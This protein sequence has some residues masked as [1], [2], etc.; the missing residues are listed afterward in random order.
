M[1]HTIASCVAVLAATYIAVWLV[2][3][4]EPPSR[5]LLDGSAVFLTTS[6]ILTI[7]F[8]ILMANAETK[9]LH[10]LSVLLG[11]L[12]ALGKLNGNF[13]E[14]VRSADSETRRILASF[15]GVFF[16]IV[17]IGSAVNEAIYLL[18]MGSLRG[19]LQMSAVAVVP[20][21]FLIAIV[22]RVRPELFGEKLPA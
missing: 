8:T 15:L 3:R 6:F 18:T 14:D 12:L 16:S 11:I 7:I 4:S 17:M 9:T 2:F 1:I 13:V 22:T 19:F 21:A 5:R 20:S 10:G